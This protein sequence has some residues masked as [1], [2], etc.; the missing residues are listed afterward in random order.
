MLKERRLSR[1]QPFTPVGSQIHRCY[2]SNTYYHLHAN[3][4]WPTFNPQ[5]QVI[6]EREVVA[7]LKDSHQQKIYKELG[8]L[9]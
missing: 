5:G 8:V 6:I 9:C 7:Q 1:L 2:W 3:S 4:K